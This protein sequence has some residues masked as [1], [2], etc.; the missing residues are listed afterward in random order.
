MP[1]GI[2]IFRQEPPPPNRGVECRWGRQKSRFWAHLAWLPVL[3]LQQSGV[4]NTV[5]GGRARPPSRKLWHIAGMCR[6]WLW[7]KTTKCL[8]Q[9]ASTLYAEDNRT[10]HLTARGNKSVPCVTNNK[11]LP[12]ST[13]CTVEANYWQTWN[14]ARPLCDSRAT[15]INSLALILALTSSPWRQVL[16]L[17]L[18]L[19]IKPL[20]LAVVSVTPSL[21]INKCCAL[22]AYE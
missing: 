18:D 11:R 10:A 12:Y 1:N 15:C 2:A 13:F 16:G 20:A 17:G 4:V 5:A 14:I 8:W 7:E 6:C 22:T 9:K 21:I 19:R 3:T